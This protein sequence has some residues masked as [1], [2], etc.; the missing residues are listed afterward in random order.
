MTTSDVPLA[1]LHH[2]RRCCRCCCC[3]RYSKMNERREAGSGI[4]AG[5]GGRRS[6]AEPTMKLF[7]EGLC[8]PRLTSHHSCERVGRLRGAGAGA[9]AAAG[10]GSPSLSEETIHLFVI[11]MSSK[12]PP[13]PATAAAASGSQRRIVIFNFSDVSCR[14]CHFRKREPRRLQLPTPPASTSPRQHLRL[15]QLEGRMFAV[16]AMGSAMSGPANRSVLPL[17]TPPR[18]EQ[19]SDAS[20]PVLPITT[21]KTIQRLPS[22]VGLGRW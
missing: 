3:C 15:S 10:A 9:A 4:G 6:G 22:W 17:L 13:P 16:P 11:R 1:H 20:T 5:T 7:R 19:N 12:S 8:R 14:R 2:R 21:N 18:S